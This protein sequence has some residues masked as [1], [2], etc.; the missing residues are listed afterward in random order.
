M[1]DRASGNWYPYNRYGTQPDCRNQA[2]TNTGTQK[3]IEE[4]LIRLERIVLDPMSEQEL[5]GVEIVRDGG[6]M[7]PLK[8]TEA[9]RMYDFSKNW[10]FAC[11]YK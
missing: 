2:Q 9:Q 6:Q 3:K 10:C 8:L 4:R 11:V 5:N 7:I 1:S